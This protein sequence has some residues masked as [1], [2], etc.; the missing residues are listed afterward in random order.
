MISSVKLGIAVIAALM[1]TY[2]RA[3]PIVSVE[4]LSIVDNES[5]EKVEQQFFDSVELSGIEKTL[6]K[7]SDKNAVFTPDM[8]KDMAAGDTLCGKLFE[9]QQGTRENIGNR[10][11]QRIYVTAHEGCVLFWKLDYSR[12]GHVW[13]INHFTFNTDH[14][15]I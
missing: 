7:F 6:V 13:A 11:E 14:N 5:I 8:L 12:Q 15:A 10:F 1:T 3:V 2:A 9:V 4:K